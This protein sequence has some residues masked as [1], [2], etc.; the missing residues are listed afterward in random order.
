MLMAV[1]A[2]ALALIEG[3][4]F[5]AVLEEAGA[6]TDLLVNAAARS[7][8]GTA[9]TVTDA[10]TE[11][12]GTELFPLR[13]DWVSTTTNPD[14]LNGVAEFSLERGI[15]VT[16]VAGEMDILLL[17]GALINSGGGRMTLVIGFMGDLFT[18]GDRSMAMAAVGD[19]RMRT[20]DEF[21]PNGISR[22]SLATGGS[23]FC[24][25]P[26]LCSLSAY[27]LGAALGLRDILL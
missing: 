1:A 18:G 6:V 16:L 19:L 12:T 10:W 24:S 3:V 20:V 7:G 27:F 25:S 9:D 13:I 22:G 17:M 5:L 26:L 11:L 4:F 23:D 14:L 15:T 21:F 8:D 2:A